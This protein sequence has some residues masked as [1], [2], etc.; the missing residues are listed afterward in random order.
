MIG[1]LYLVFLVSTT[2][3]IIYYLYFFTAFIRFKPEEITSGAPVSVI[4][5]ARDEAENLKKNLPLFL[6]QKHP[7][8]EV[9]VIDDRSVDNT[10]EILETFKQKYP[11]KLRVNKIAFNRWKTFRG[12]KKYALTLGIKSARYNRLLLTDADCEPASGE[13]ISHMTAGFNE[14]KKIILGYGKYKKKSGLLNLLIR[15]ETLHTAMQYFSYALKG[16]PYMGVGRNLAYLK[17]FFLEKDGFKNHFHILSGDD[18]LFINENA[19]AQ[20]TGLCIN[21]EAHT[22]SEPET[23]WSGWF[24]QKRRH[25][26]TARFYKPKHKFL[27]G[28][29]S[30]SILLFWLSAVLIFSQEGFSPVLWLGTIRLV[31]WILLIHLAGKKLKDYIFPFSVVFLEPLLIVLQFLIFISNK[32]KK[33]RTWT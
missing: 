2:T 27:L 5:S 25:Y 12:N 26:T 19:T 23:S 14:G 31:L 11:Q 15:Y 17:D 20:N 28:I 7:A 32:I 33:P 24:A 30:A 21:P 8:Y 1:M 4:I 3:L 10:E 22:L 18:D 6:K 9:L 29:Y 16:I 13:W